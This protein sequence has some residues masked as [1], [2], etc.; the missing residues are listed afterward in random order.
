MDGNSFKSIEYTGPR[1]G[2]VGQ[3]TDRSL[4]VPVVLNTKLALGHN[5]ESLRRRWVVYCHVGF[6]PSMP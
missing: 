3:M 5:E 6:M 2:A 4:E 1:D